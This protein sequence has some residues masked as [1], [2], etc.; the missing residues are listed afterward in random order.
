VSLPLPI[1]HQGSAMSQWPK[2]YSSAFTL[3]LPYLD[4]IYLSVLLIPEAEP[5]RPLLLLP[6]RP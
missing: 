2:A 3:Y 4:I 1:S 6:P 5:A